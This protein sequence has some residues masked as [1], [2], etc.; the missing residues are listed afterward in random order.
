[1]KL[2]STSPPRGVRER[3]LG[4]PPPRAAARATARHDH[5]PP[6]WGQRGKGRES[7]SPARRSRGRCSKPSPWLRWRT[8]PIATEE[9]LPNGKSHRWP[10]WRRRRLLRRRP[11][12]GQ[13]ALPVSSEN[14]VNAASRLAARG[15]ATGSHL[16]PGRPAP[17]S[18]ATATGRRRSCAPH[19]PIQSRHDDQWSQVPHGA[20]FQRYQGRH[21]G[22]AARCRARARTQA[23]VAAGAHRWRWTLRRGAAHGSG[24]RPGHGLRRVALPP[25]SA[26]AGVPAPRPSC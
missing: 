8:L 17:M 20:G 25:T 5:P 26:N 11:S 2:C 19:V 9:R 18:S 7:S 13:R 23:T 3:P 6:P 15:A 12:D 22:G 1:M 10:G 16:V 14:A 21:Q 4:L 24:T